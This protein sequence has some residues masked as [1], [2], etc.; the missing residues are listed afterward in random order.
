MPRQDIRSLLIEQNKNG[1]ER[2]RAKSSALHI[3][4]VWLAK[5]YFWMASDRRA[6]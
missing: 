2:S 5:A 6:T 3:V 1:Q 4:L